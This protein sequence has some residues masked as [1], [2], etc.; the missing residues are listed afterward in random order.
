M[1]SIPKNVVELLKKYTGE[2]KPTIIN[3]KDDRRTF[4]NEFSEANQNLVLKWI[5]GNKMLIVS[6]IIRGSGQFS[7]EWILVAQKTK[8]NARWVLKPINTVINHF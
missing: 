7:A 4:I 5:K 8:I 6:D 1:W 2:V 3:P